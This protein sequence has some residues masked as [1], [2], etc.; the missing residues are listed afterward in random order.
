MASNDTS[1]PLDLHYEFNQLSLVDLLHARDTYHFHLMN[2]QNVVGTAVGYYLIRNSDPPPDKHGKVHRV[3]GAKTPREF[4]NSGV[5]DYSWPCVLV[6][7]SKWEDD[8]QFGGGR[9]YDPTQMVPKTLFLPD[10]QAVPV[11]VVLTSESEST[12]ER[13]APPPDVPPTWKLGGGAPI[14]VTSQGVRRLA[15]AGCL[16]TDGHYSYVLTAAHVCGDE[17]TPVTSNMR[18]SEVEIGRSSG[19]TLTNL[20]F[21]TAYPEFPTRRSYSTVDVGLIKLDDITGWTSNVYGL[22]ALGPLEDAH[23][24]NLSLRLIDRQ[25]V[26]YG[27]A[28]GLLRGTIKALFYRYR[29]VGG[30]DYVADYLIAPG[31]GP[32]T[33]HGDSGMIWNLDVTRETPDEPVPLALRE[34]RPL[35]VEWGGQSFADSDKTRTFAVASNLSTVCRQLDV[36]LVT[37]VSRGVSGFWGRV[38]H[39]SIASFAAGLVENPQLHE[40]LTNEPVLTML[41]FDLDVIKG[42]K[43]LEDILKEIG[44]K[45]G[46]TPLADVPDEVWKKLPPPK[47]PTDPPPTNRRTGGRDKWMGEKLKVNGPEHPN[48]YADIDAPFDSNG[49]NWRDICLTDGK[50]I[51][52]KAWQGFYAKMAAEAP[53]PDVAAQY[54]EPLKQGLL[55]L[56]V[57][58]IF[59][60]M[61]DFVQ[62]KDITGFVAAAGVCAH[63]VGDA[64]QPLHGSVLADGDP[65]RHTDRIGDDGKPMKYGQ[66]VHTLYESDMVSRFADPLVTA[67]TAKLPDGHGLALAGDGKAAAKAT[68]QLMADV[69]E[70]L[71]PQRILDSFEDHLVNGRPV[72]ATQVGMWGDLSEETAD[73]LLL[74]ARTL[75]MIWEAAWKKGGGK[76]SLLKDPP[77]RDDVQA[78]YVDVDFLPSRVLDKVSE[79]LT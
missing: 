31:D 51:S 57:W 78:R 58:Q 23:E 75:A 79:Y 62:S 10:G 56:R 20:P 53:D 1:D 2:K 41:S 54:A 19:K 66:G 16:V 15:T 70:V 35:A 49:R 27:A 68:L 18:G 77:S 74:G 52:V 30:F 69:A 3:A 25:V 39:Y 40:F 4:G 34:L 32:T 63:Y 33:R 45:D 43:S 60:A 13:V 55:P 7:V 5:R 22:P 67:I 11:C 42:G 12:P 50:N 21:S 46:F 36:Q 38:G 28:S 48:H 8:D 65:A 29:S 9:P 73:V 6:M 37:D 44:K 14:S 72:V 24:R 76:A 17:G 64:S 71:P 61:V 47:H 59:S 26:G